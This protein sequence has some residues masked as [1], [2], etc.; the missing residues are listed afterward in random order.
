ML[1][2]G[3]SDLQC[4][5]RRSK[6]YFYRHTRMRTMLRRHSHHPEAKKTLFLR[7]AFPDQGLAPRLDIDSASRQVILVKANDLG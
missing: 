2:Q 6:Q 5:E 3:C 1:V 4:Q 7:S